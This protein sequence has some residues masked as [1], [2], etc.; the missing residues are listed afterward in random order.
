MEDTDED[1]KGLLFFELI[2]NLMESDFI[3]KGTSVSYSS[4][5]LFDG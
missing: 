3:V 4:F 5:K 2:D 1:I